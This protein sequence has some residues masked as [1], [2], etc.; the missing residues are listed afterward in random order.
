MYFN[1]SANKILKFFSISIIKTLEFFF[2]FPS[3]IH[4]YFFGNK[5]NKHLYHNKDL[6]LNYSNFAKEINIYIENNFKDIIYKNISNNILN[7]KK[8]YYFDL[9]NYLPDDYIYNKIYNFLDSQ[10]IKKNISDN[11][12]YSVR[13][14]KFQLFVNFHNPLCVENEDSKLLHRDSDSLCGQLK[15]FMVLNDLSNED[16]G[17]L[18]YYIPE[19]KIPK[20]VKISEEKNGRVMNSLNYYTNKDFIK[21]GN[22]QGEILVLNTNDTYHKGGYINKENCCR[23]MIVAIYSPKFLS[24]SILENAFKNNFLY[25]ILTKFLIFFKNKV[26]ICI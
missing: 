12:N 5:L 11:F 15:L 19:V 1:I 6:R 10:E 7:K 21:F 8:N 17:G 20:Y 26:R 3:I 14:T 18:F 25:R 23:L 16:F 9:L 4:Y 2:L 24:I 22:N 13:F